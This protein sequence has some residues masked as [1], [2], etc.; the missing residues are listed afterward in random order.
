MRRLP[1]IADATGLAGAVLMLAT[2]SVTLNAAPA[3]PPGDIQQILGVW[4]GS[5]LCQFKDSPCHDETVVYYVTAG[6][7][8]GKFQVRANKIV[9]GEEQA[10]GTIDCTSGPETGSYTCRTDEST[11]WTWKLQKDVLSGELQLRGQLY[12]KIRVTRAK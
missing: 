12:R 6:A 10:M 2:A 1:I 9:G 4:R 7:A 5:S 8:A 11:V 3:V